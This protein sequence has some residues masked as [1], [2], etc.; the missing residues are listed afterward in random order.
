MLEIRPQQLAVFEDEV[1]PTLVAEATARLALR[2]GPYFAALGPA[3]VRAVVDHGMRRAERL[4]AGD[5]AGID[6]VTE[7]VLILGAGFDRDPLLPWVGEALAQARDG[8]TAGEL[9]A[10]YGLVSRYV[11]ETAGPSGTAMRRALQRLAGFDW[12]GW[13]VP[14]SQRRDDAIGSV[15]T[16]LYPEKTDA[17]A[18]RGLLDTLL[19]T[20]EAT[21]MRHGLAD[22]R[23][24]LLC[25][26]LTLSL[27]AHFDDDPQFPWARE[28]ASTTA[29]LGA[30]TQFLQR[31]IA[32]VEA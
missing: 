3:V 30:A 23:G 1:R 20:G 25:V 7:L 15:I 11:E 12:G 21:A 27:G 29:L 17:L 18:R 10:L 9:P 24:T 6:T 19:R 4:G 14:P 22:D 2:H 26:V 5:A 13:S 28:F 31:V 32:A 8:D 16:A